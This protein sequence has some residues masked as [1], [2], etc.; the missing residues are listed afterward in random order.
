MNYP[1]SSNLCCG[2]KWCVSHCIFYYLTVKPSTV[3]CTVSNF[4]CSCHFPRWRACFH[5]CVAKLLFFLDVFVIF[6]RKKFVWFF[7]SIPYYIIAMSE[8]NSN[9]NMDGT[10]FSI[11]VFPLVSPDH[12]FSYLCPNWV[13]IFLLVNPFNFFL[14]TM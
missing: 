6:L 7:Q 12:Y 2:V 3:C 9:G 1:P 11:I 13:N 8:S 4:E 10:L 14:V 5:V